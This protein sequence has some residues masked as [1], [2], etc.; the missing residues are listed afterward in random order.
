MNDDYLWDRSGE[1]DPEVERLENLLEPLRHRPGALDFSRGPRTAAARPLAWGGTRLLAVAAGLSL[2]VAT[3]VWQTW[4]L[5]APDEAGGGW[6]ASRVQGSPAVDSGRLVGE[7]PV[8]PDQWIET[9]KFTSV[10]L[11]AEAVGSVEVRPG[12]RLRVVRARPG[13]YRLALAM[14][15]LHARI[16]A[17]PG[18][19]AVETPSA[20]ALDLG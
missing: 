5:Q 13:Q 10:R 6:L 14:G 9:D 1:P 17:P 7:G 4:P 11:M 20:V 12:S 8:V 15:S 19:F 2:V 18:R 16:W 3:G